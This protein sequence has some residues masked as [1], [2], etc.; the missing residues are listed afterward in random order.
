MSEGVATSDNNLWYFIFLKIK[1]FI[2][3]GCYMLFYG[4]LLF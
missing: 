2:Y 4:I 3:N 1:F